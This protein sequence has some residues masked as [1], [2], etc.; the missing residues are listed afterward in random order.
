MNGQS[1]L[2]SHK[3]FL[4]AQE[5][6]AAPVIIPEQRAAE[7]AELANMLSL[8]AAMKELHERILRFFET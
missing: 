8:R 7:T 4:E 3:R 5:E 2:L 6:V 1:K